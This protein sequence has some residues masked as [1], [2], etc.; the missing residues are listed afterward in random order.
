LSQVRAIAVADLAPGNARRWRAVR[1]RTE[2]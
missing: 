2:A 1:L